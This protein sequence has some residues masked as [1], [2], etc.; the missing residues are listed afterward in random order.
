M[1]D[2]QPH[3]RALI[4]PFAAVRV[5][6][7]VVVGGKGANL[8][9]L[10]AAG[11]P[12][13]PGFCITTAAFEHFMATQVDGERLYALL[14]ALQP[15][16]I[17]QIRQ[18]GQQ[19]RDALR[20]ASM[21]Q[22]VAHAIR[23]AWQTL[24]R[25]HAYAVRSSA[26]AEDLPEASFAGQQDTFLNVRGE[27]AL[28]ADVQHCW[29]SLFTDRAILYRLQHCVD[30]RTVRMAV[31]VQR[32][33]EPQVSGIMFTADPVT[34]NRS[35]IAIDASFGLGEALVSGTVS[36]DLYQ[37]DKR[38]RRIV[39]RQIGDKHMQIRAQTE[40][41]VAQVEVP[42]EMRERPSLTDAQVLELA[43]LG[44]QIEAHFGTPQDV[45]WALR[46]GHY[47]ILQARPITTLYPLPQP[48]PHEGALHIYFSFNHFQVMTDPLPNLV[49]SLW[50]I[51][52]GA[53]RP[54]GAL[55]NPYLA[56]AG[57][58]IYIDVSPLLRHRLLGRVVPKAFASVDVLAA[59][60]MAAVAKRPA[61]RRRG[62][63]VSLRSLLRWQGPVLG[64]AMLR[65]VWTAP[66]GTPAL[67]LRLMDRYLAQA[68]ARLAAAPTPLARL[69]V[70]VALLLDLVPCIF[71]DWFPYFVAGELANS[72]LQRIMHGIAASDDL[73]AVTRGLH[74]NVVTEMNLAVGDLADL[75]RQSSALL[76]H[77]S[78]PDVA[79]QTLLDTA[80][81]VP[82]GSAFSVAWQQFIEQYGM[83]APAEIDLSRPRW[84]EDPSSLLQ[85]V[86][87]T[88]RQ[89]EIGVH[90]AHYSRLAAEGEA[91][92]RRLVKAAGRGLWGW[93]RTPL[94]RRLVRVVRQLLPTREHHKFW[95]IR[96]LGLLKPVF[97]EVGARLVAEGRLERADDVWFLTIPE[98]LVALDHVEQP[99]QKRIAERRGALAHFRSL[100]PPRVMTSEGDIPIVTLAAADAPPGALVGTPASAGVVEGIARV[101]R[102]PQTTTLNHGEILVAAFTDPGWTPLFIN[103]AGVVTEVGGMMTHGSVVAREYGIPAVVG[104]VDATKRIGEGQ[105]IRVHGTAGYVELLATDGS[106]PLWTTVRLEGL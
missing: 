61:F 38:E 60:A 36:A 35:I 76:G 31:V 6:D 21:P 80:A 91:A 52:V 54:A 95:M 28:L 1:D 37:V 53:G 88:A 12:V 25:E 44:M 5:T 34:G 58:R 74:G 66:E 27:A 69:K 62:Q 100:T 55:E 43:A 102:D 49:I 17:K 105:R 77:L 63:A 32:M 90:R 86:L 19:I 40:G 8:G 78:Q 82:G 51:L 50:R 81:T 46:A 84:H 98:L 75:V 70:A 103:A 26:T 71:R 48:T 41:G 22:D 56:A 65:L 29:A 97:L 14:D 93:V 3:A 96:L 39:M 4:L 73:V 79:A 57:G 106:T 68:E 47:A 11:F 18:V 13:P 94:V 15:G 89:S 42:H 59:Q 64:R 24:G 104:V 92:A 99:L 72:L 101:I 67:G 16:D 23:E 20:S 83:R 30:H 85:M 33:V 2:Q 9:E 7:V 45:E 87:S 10:T